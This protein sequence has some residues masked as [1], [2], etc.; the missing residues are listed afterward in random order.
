[1]QVR[2]M[3]RIGDRVESRIDRGRI[4]IGYF[5]ENISNLY[6]DE[7]LSVSIRINLTRGRMDSVTYGTVSSAEDE[8]FVSC[9]GEDGSFE[10]RG[11]DDSLGQGEHFTT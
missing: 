1:M 4:V 7:I 6:T 10:E 5:R 8:I 2:S 11:R 9:D 3:S